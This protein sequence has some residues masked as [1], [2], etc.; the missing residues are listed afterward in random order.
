MV[1]GAGGIR[2]S[3]ESSLH[4]YVVVQKLLL[5]CLCLQEALVPEILAW[6][7]T[8]EISVKPWLFCGLL[9]VLAAP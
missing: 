3:S 7:L 1:V 4:H 9:C 5:L 6:V 8:S 2:R